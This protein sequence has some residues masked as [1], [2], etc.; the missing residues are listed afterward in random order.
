MKTL[1]TAN[2][3]VRRFFVSDK[4]VNLKLYFEEALPPFL[5]HV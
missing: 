2:A 1:N 4:F 5:L 3:L